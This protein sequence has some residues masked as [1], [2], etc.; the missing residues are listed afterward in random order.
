MTRA[1]LTTL[2]LIAALLRDLAE[3]GRHESAA[4]GSSTVN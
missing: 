4:G 3:A 2:A 1:L